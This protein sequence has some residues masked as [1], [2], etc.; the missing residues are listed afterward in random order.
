[1]GKKLKVFNTDRGGEYLG[2]E[3]SAFLDSQGIVRKLSVHNMHQEAG[4]A[5][6]RNRTI[7]E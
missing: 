4:I 7:A 3:F 5:E 2:K 1:M 6:R